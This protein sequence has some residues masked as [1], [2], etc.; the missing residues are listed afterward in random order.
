M[1]MTTSPFLRQ[2]LQ[3]QLMFISALLVASCA[4]S[5]PS[6]NFNVVQ[7]GAD[8]SGVRDS[9]EAI[10]KTIQSAVDGRGNVFV[11]PGEFLVS[12]TLTV[13]GRVRIQG[14]GRNSK[15][16]TA[17]DGKP[18]LGDKSLIVVNAL[19][20]SPLDGIVIKDLHVEGQGDPK[21]SPHFFEN[22]HAIV[23]RRAVSFVIENVFV[24]N[25]GGTAFKLE[26]SYSGLIQ[27]CE[28]SNPGRVLEIIRIEEIGVGSNG[29]LVN[30]MISS[31]AAGAG[32]IIAGS[33]GVTLNGSEFQGGYARDPRRGRGQPA[34]VLDGVSEG[35]SVVAAT[36]RV[37]A[38][39]ARLARYK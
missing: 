11:P 28:A 9:T 37:T 15:I 4:A 13:S 27:N 20:A 5:E 7:Y 38:K 31:Q 17:R 6:L 16:K 21:T 29:V 34:L 22:E 1:N 12:D 25:I 24:E 33:N 26:A 3:R 36:I 8:P 30:K 32:A 23:L 14:M 19:S 39:A 18:L 2:A 35:I 10:Q